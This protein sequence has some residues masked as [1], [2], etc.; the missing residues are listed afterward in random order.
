VMDYDEP[1]LPFDDEWYKQIP[2]LHRWLLDDRSMPFHRA[3]PH[4]MFEVDFWFV[5]FFLM[6][7][8]LGWSDCPEGIARLLTDSATLEGPVTLL[9]DV[10]GERVLGP[11][12]W[13]A[14]AN[15]DKVSAGSAGLTFAERGLDKSFEEA[16]DREGFT[17]GWD[18]KHLIG[19]LSP[20]VRP[21]QEGHLDTPRARAALEGVKIAHEHQQRRCVLLVR[22]YDQWP[23]A[24][25]VLG[26][27]LPEGPPSWR[28]HVVT[29]D[30]G[31]V[32]EFRRCWDCGWWFQGPARFHQ[33]GHAV[34]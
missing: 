22:S 28:V 12:G 29:E 24:L 16:A 4:P 1:H 13:W 33:W 9:R 21:L 5:P 18:P 10:W 26:N 17:G 14:W 2:N 31:V 25:A 11:L 27:D 23:T 3:Y 20:C 19:H 15:A 32:G 8:I 34:D 7:T 30:H 6:R